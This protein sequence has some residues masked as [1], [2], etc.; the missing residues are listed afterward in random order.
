LLRAVVANLPLKVT[1]V[2]VAVVI[3]AFAVLDRTYTRT[4]TVPVVVAQADA[5]RMLVETDT[6][7]AQVTIQARGKDL[8]GVHFRQLEFRVP[9]TE[10]RAGTRQVRLLAEDMKLPS[11][12]VVRSIRPEFVELR[13]N[14][15]AGKLVPIRVPT[16]GQ[17]ASGLAVTVIPPTVQARLFGSAEELK[18]VDA[19]A[20]ETLSMATVA[21]PGV[22]RL[23]LV[24]P[25]GRFTGVEPESV[26]VTIALE[27]EGARIFLGVPVKVVAPAGRSVELDPEEAQIAVAGPASKIDKLSDADVSAEVKVSGLPPGE[28]RL[29]AEITLPPEFHMVKCEPQFFDVLVK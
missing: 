5:K 23:A 7:E 29:A 11:G 15:A 19:V 18:L 14:E 26:D 8:I 1:A 21:Q 25:Q 17:V 9:V 13:Q 22:R 28:Y 27:R 12:V 3:W 6:T 24:L 20:T 2:V 16:A 10:T 4:F